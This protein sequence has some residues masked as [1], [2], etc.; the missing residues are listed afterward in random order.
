[1]LGVLVGVLMA[2]GE[3][4]AQRP[5]RVIVPFAPNNNHGVALSVFSEIINR[6]IREGVVFEYHAGGLGLAAMARFQGNND[7]RTF[8]ITNSNTYSIM[9]M[10]E[11]V[12]YRTDDLEPLAWLTVTPVCLAVHP[13]HRGTTFTQY[14]PQA[15]GGFYGVLTENS[16]DSLYF[17]F[18]NRRENLGQTPVYYKYYPDVM[19]AVL[20]GEVQ[21]GIVPAIWCRRATDQAAALAELSSTPAQ[22]NTDSW[23][24]NTWFGLFGRKNADRKMQQEF[25]TRFADAWWRSRETLSRTVTYPPQDLRGQE[26]RKMIDSYQN[27]WQGLI[28]NGS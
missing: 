8:L 3:T 4:L 10:M 11:Q 1:M 12:S 2:H 19:A 24:G 7:E 27:Q 26:F 21:W 9:P 28:R 20:K 17:R 6:D 22:Y 15:R 16:V 13:R 14:L 18:V 5:Y 23:F 25:M